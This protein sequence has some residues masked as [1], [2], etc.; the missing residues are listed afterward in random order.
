MKPHLT[1]TPDGEIVYE[2]TTKRRLSP[3]VERGALVGRYPPYEPVAAAI[4]RRRSVEGL[5]HEYEAA[6]I[7]LAEQRGEMWSRIRESGT[8]K[9]V[10]M[11]ERYRRREEA[12]SDDELRFIVSRGLPGRRGAA[13]GRPAPEPTEGGDV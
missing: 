9:V 11:E 8:R 10:A 7:A 12:R 5:A 4:S 1:T 3:H 13:P 2:K 6:Q